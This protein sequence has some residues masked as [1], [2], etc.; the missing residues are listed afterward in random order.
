[1]FVQL[2]WLVLGWV[3]LPINDVLQPPRHGLHQVPQVLA[4]VQLQHPQLSDFPLQLLQ[5]LSLGAPQLHLH[6]GPDILNGVQVRAV[7]RPVH[8]LD[9]G[10]L[11]EP[12]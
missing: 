1:M 6:P 5:V 9:V 4:V 7:A 10:P 3:A 11:L 2:I 12:G 8:E